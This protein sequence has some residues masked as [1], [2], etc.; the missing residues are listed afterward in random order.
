MNNPNSATPGTVVAALYRF[1]TFPEYESLREPLKQCML[2]NDVRGTLLLAAEG[3]NGTIAGSRAGVDAV[4]AFLERDARFADLAPKES[5]AAENPFYRT[6]VKLKREIVTMG[7]EDIDPKKIVGTYVEPSEW[8]ALISD[9]EVLLLDTRNK[10]EVEIGTFES[11]RFIET[12]R[13]KVRANASDGAGST[14]TIDV[15]D[16]YIMGRQALAKA[17]SFV[18]GNGPVPQIR[19]GPVVDSLMRFNPMGWYW[20]GGYGL[21]RQA[22]LRRIESSSS[23]GVNA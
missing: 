4:I 3:I 13:T 15:Y 14:G 12:P 10:Y 2:D 5:F 17:Y 21:F 23:I 1:A 22:S 8:N 7:V 11:V 16:T 18:D 6:K 20:L 9:P 19:R